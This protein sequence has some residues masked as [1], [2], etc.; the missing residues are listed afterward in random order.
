VLA[1][2]PALGVEQGHDI[3]TAA[4]AA[5]RSALPQLDA[6]SV[7]IEPQGVGPH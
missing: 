1:V 3:A 4:T 2:D 6:V 7:H 5:M